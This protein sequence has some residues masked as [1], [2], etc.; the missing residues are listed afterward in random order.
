MKKI[1]LI[2]LS[3]MM[4]LFIQVRVG[5]VIT[6][7]EYDL[8]FTE[9]V[10]FNLETGTYEE[11]DDYSST[12]RIRIL[13]DSLWIR[14]FTVGL[15]LEAHHVLFWTDTNQYLG[16]QN[17][18]ETSYEGS[19]FLGNATLPEIKI[20]THA[21]KFSIVARHT[22]DDT[23]LI[24]HELTLDTPISQ[25]N[26]HTLE[27]V[28]EDL[29]HEVYDFTL[30]NDVVSGFS[31]HDGKTYY[32]QRIKKYTLQASDII[33]INTNYTQIDYARITRSKLLN[34]KYITITTPLAP[35]A[36][37]SILP[38][39]FGIKTTP[40]DYD[41]SDYINHFDAG[42]DVSN[43]WVGLNKGT[44]LTEAQAAL[45]GT[46]IY[47]QLA[48]PIETEI[49]DI[50]TLTVEQMDHWYNV[51]TRVKKKTDVTYNDFFTALDITPTNESTVTT[52]NF[53]LT[54]PLWLYIDTIGITEK[55]IYY[56]Y[57]SNGTGADESFAVQFDTDFYTFKI[58]ST[59]SPISGSDYYIQ[60]AETDG[61]I[62][63]WLDTYN[64]TSEFTNIYLISTTPFDN[65]FS[66]D[67]FTSY[68]LT[69]SPEEVIKEWYD[70]DFEYLT[71]A[72]LLY[73][74]YDH[75]STNYA[76]WLAEY[77]ILKE[78]NAISYVNFETTFAFYLRDVVEEVE[79][80]LDERIDEWLMDVGLDS[81]FS[82]IVIVVVLM[83]I[84]AII[85]ALVHAPA[86][87]I[88]IVE[89]FIV[90]IFTA[91]GFIPLWMDVVIA[92]LFG[93]LLYLKLTNGNGGEE[94]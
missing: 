85:L 88:M 72:K 11:D 74:T 31:V 60:T 92:L 50:D 25:L 33:S 86:I 6:Q 16:Y 52:V 28:F 12:A 65:T 71:E 56:D 45:A 58:Y 70:L 10:T 94:E 63:W 84:F 54:D 1:F 5:A 47:Y 42:A 26:N 91:L 8:T 23:K 15:D 13:Y 66:P 37:T 21:R 9:G 29:P 39:G 76:T 36:R 41:N 82:K 87:L 81:T 43:I 46:V 61:S 55:W 18:V 7:F 24:P 53:G 80:D 67:G 79:L 93:G 14:N 49:L 34:W 59:I 78:Y 27:E 17:L 19:K 30:P 35:L 22:D 90:I 40:D 83:A 44:T 77:S 38:A 32:V 20:P 89:A 75:I 64:D 69:S 57:A 68:N 3:V 2:V 62:T 4:L 48:T 51:Y 73:S